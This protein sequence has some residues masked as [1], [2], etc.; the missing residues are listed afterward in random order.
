VN[1][2]GD[3]RDFYIAEPDTWKMLYRIALNRKAREFDPALHA[4]RHLLSETDTKRSKKVHERL[5]QVEDILTV[6]D[7]FLSRFLESEEKS[8][9]ILGFFKNFTPK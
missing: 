7:H 6:L 5:D 9:T 8:K 1:I 4:L 2:S 3:R